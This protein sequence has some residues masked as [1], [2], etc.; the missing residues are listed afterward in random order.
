MLCFLKQDKNN[1]IGPRKGTVELNHH[2]TFTI[3]DPKLFKSKANLNNF[4]AGCDESEF[5]PNK[6]ESVPPNET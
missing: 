2:E 6:I 4:F 1:A 5:I 3:Y